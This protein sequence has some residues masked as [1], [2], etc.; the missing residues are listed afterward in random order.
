MTWA[1]VIGLA[2]LTALPV[3]AQRRFEIHSRGMLHETVF[4]TGLGPHPK[5]TDLIEF[6]HRPHSMATSDHDTVDN[7]TTLM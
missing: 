6:P 4:N 2:V 7:D 1:L 3:Q 5:I